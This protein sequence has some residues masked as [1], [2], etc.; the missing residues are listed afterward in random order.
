MTIEHYEFGRIKIDGQVYTDDVIVSPDGVDDSWWRGKGHELC[1]AD[2]E[3]VWQARPDILLIG[4]GARGVLAVLP[5]AHKEMQRKC[6]QVH[7]LQTDEAV[8]RYNQLAE[9]EEGR[10]RV[11][12]ALH[13]TC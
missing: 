2:L 7:V 4:T 6:D 13:L 1:C 12:A 9:K 5:E 3:P 10:R 8:E 11:V